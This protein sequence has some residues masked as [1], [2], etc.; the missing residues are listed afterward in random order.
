MQGWTFD[1]LRVGRVT[2][3]R[4]SV[5]EPVE[6]EAEIGIETTLPPAELQPFEP[7]P[8]EPAAVGHSFTGFHLWDPDGSG[9]LTGTGWCLVLLVI[10]G[11]AAGIGV[12]I[13][14]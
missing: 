10:A 4:V 11:G 12:W 6:F 8:L 7:P 1:S 14:S 13:T 9:G 5:I 2:H 3:Q